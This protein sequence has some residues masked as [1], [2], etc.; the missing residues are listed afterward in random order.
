MNKRGQVAVFLIVGILI[1]VVAGLVFFFINNSTVDDIKT[2]DTSLD[3]ERDAVKQY[4]EACLEVNLAD[5]VQFTSMQGGYFGVPD[6][7]VR[8]ELLGIDN[9]YIYIPYYLDS[10]FDT[11][12]TKERFEQEIAFGT[13][14]YL[15]RCTNFSLFSYDV[16]ADLQNSQ[17][18]AKLSEEYVI[19]EITLPVTI[20]L[21]DK[22]IELEKFNIKVPSTANH[23]FETAKEINDLQKE[24]QNDVC[25]TCFPEI[26]TQ[27][28]VNLE[29]IQSETNDGDE[30]VILYDLSDLEE[31]LSFTFAQKFDI[32]D[33]KIFEDLS[34]IPIDQITIKVGE[35]WD[36]TIAATGVG[37]SYADDSELIDVDLQTGKIEFTP[38]IDDLGD[39]VIT[40]TV[41]DALG[42]S[43]EEIFTLIVETEMLYYSIQSI[44]YLNAKVGEP[45]TY[46][47]DL[48]ADENVNYTFSDDS[49]LFE[50][51]ALTGMIEFTPEESH[52][53]EHMFNIVVTNSED[54]QTV[55]DSGYIIIDE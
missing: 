39:Y 32:A 19:S 40:F 25:I 47:V 13:D 49:Y 36:Y 33:D 43:E 53:G 14:A 2:E 52:A 11:M 46:Q 24:N 5:V 22:K 41:S 1:L 51:D 17:V 3:P 12:I 4:L 45:F 9:Q 54:D 20:T 38:T 23:L 28:N 42:N 26:M 34:I 8:Y 16:A 31:Q 55:T 37:L 29:T 27:Y 18:K 44:G 15:Y 30:Y 35:T 48:L 7:Y 21:A 50:I 6:H 10:G